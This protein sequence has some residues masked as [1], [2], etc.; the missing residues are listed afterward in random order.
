VRV[1]V[2]S[3]GHGSQ[4]WFALHPVRDVVTRQPA[5]Q[6]H[7]ADAI[8][9]GE[10]PTTYQVGA[11]A[12]DVTP[13]H[14]IR[15][16]GYSGRQTESDG[17]VQRLWAKA[18]VINSPQRPAAL[19]IT[20]DNCLIPAYLRS[21]LATRLQR[22][23]GLHPDRFAITATHTHNGPILANMSETL[24]CHPLPKAHREHIERY[25]LKLID[26]LEHVAVTAFENQQAARLFWSRGQVGFARNRRTKGGPVDHELPVL[27]IKNLAGD[28]RAV[29]VSYACHCTTLSHNKV[30]G[31]WAG[32]AQAQIQRSYPG[33]IAL[34]SAGC[35]GDANPRAGANQDETA[36]QHGQE[37]SDEV[38]RLLQPRLNGGL[39]PI[40]GELDARF[41]RV[42]LQLAKIP[43]RAQWEARAK[44]DS[45]RGGTVGYHARIHLERL[46]RNEPI[47][48]KV[49]LPV[50]TWTF[51][52][53]LAIVFLGGEAVVDYA[54]R[55][56]KELDHRRV[57]INAYAN[58][59]PCYIPSERVLREGGYEGGGAMT[60]HD[61]ASPFL[62]GLEKQIVDEVHYQLGKT[63]RRPH[64]HIL[65]RNP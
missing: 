36:A 57:W 24:Y 23:I 6:E 43:S 20:L 21:E 37:I 41:A 31:D 35:G 13:D 15:L 38:S 2:R 17:V 63:Y 56:K 5:K 12:V 26:K 51:A 8:V 59:V 40:S 62:P 28:V 30:S 44:Q 50:Q 55:L 42:N 29:Y 18:L 32:Y 11:A 10:E 58:D 64:P 22:R 45:D 14:P 34:V 3:L 19:L 7:P 27:V 49:P 9:D 16:R 33:A 52:D 60:F 53:D 25:T 39:R 61:W 54:V 47:K 65:E 4:R 48:T 46:D 1:G